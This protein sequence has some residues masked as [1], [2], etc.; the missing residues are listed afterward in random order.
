M[1]LLQFQAGK[2]R[3]GIDV[4]RVIEV[5]PMVVFRPLPHADPAVAGLF[6]YRG[7]MVPV[8]DLTVLLEGAASR[9]LFSTRVILV[10]YPGRDGECHIL[11]L[12]AERVTETVFCKEEDL[13]PAGIAVTGAPYLGDLLIHAGGMIQ[14][15]AIERLLPTSLQE[16]LFPQALEA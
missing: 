13:L 16:T 8:I 4:S 10:D 15:V 12:L 14:R 1:L 5:I 6:N 2:D 9:P 3:Y 7:T 11:G